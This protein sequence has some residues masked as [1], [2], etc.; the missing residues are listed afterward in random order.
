MV[1][2]RPQ[3]GGGGGAAEQADKGPVILAGLA[4][5][6]AVAGG[7]LRGVV[8]QMRCFGEH[9]DSLNPFTRLSFARSITTIRSDTTT[10][11]VMDFRWPEFNRLPAGLPVPV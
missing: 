6:A 8:E 7:N 1:D 2:Q 11:Q 9:E 4:L 10:S 3:D 5:P